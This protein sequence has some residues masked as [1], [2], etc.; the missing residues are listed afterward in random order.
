MAFGFVTVIVPS[1]VPLST[2]IDGLKLL[3][4]AGGSACANACPA[5]EVVKRAASN[6]FFMA[7][8][9][10]DQTGRSTAA[11]RPIRNTDRSIGRDALSKRAA[12]PIRLIEVRAPFRSQDPSICAYFESKH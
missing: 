6:N 3:V 4:I 2:T 9:I 12:V 7:V 11:D 10:V 5:N 1:E 8:T